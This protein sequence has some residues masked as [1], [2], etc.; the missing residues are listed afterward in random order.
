[1]SEEIQ[2]QGQDVS[3]DLTLSAEA[4]VKKFDEIFL[5]DAACPLP[6]GL[7]KPFIP[8]L[9]VTTDSEELLKAWKEAQ[10]TA[11]DAKDQSD[12][13]QNEASNNPTPDNL[14]QASQAYNAWV[15]AQKAADKAGEAYQDALK[16]EQKNQATVDDLKR[17]IKDTDNK[18]FTFSEGERAG[19]LKQISDLNQIANDWR[20]D[21]QNFVNMANTGVLGALDDIIVGAGFDQLSGL[22]SLRLDGW[23]ILGHLEDL[24]KFC[25]TF[26]TFVLGLKPEWAP[27]FNEWKKSFSDLG[28]RYRAGLDLMRSGIDLTNAADLEKLS[29]LFGNKNIAKDMKKL[30]DALKYVGA[31]D[32]EVNGLL[33]SGQEMVGAAGAMADA[34]CNMLDGAGSLINSV[35]AIQWA[36]PLSKSLGAWKNPFV[37]FNKMIRIPTPNASFQTLAKWQGMFNMDLDQWDEKIKAGGTC[38]W[39][40]SV[41]KS[42]YTSLHATPNPLGDPAK[43][44][45]IYAAMNPVEALLEGTAYA[46]GISLTPPA[47]DPPAK[48]A[49][50]TG[51]A[52]QDVNAKA[53]AGIT[54]AIAQVG[55]SYA[56]GVDAYAA[57]INAWIHG[58][59][60]AKRFEE[61]LNQPAKDRLESELQAAEDALAASE[62]ELQAAEDAMQAASDDAEGLKGAVTF[63]NNTGAISVGSSTNPAAGGYAASNV[64]TGARIDPETGMAVTPIAE[65]AVVN[66]I[67]TMKD[68]ASIS[69]SSAALAPRLEELGKLIYELGKDPANEDK[70]REAVAAFLSFAAAMGLQLNF[71]VDEDL[72][73]II[74]AACAFYAKQKK[75]R[76]DAEKELAGNRGGVPVDVEVKNL[77]IRCWL[78]AYQ[79]EAGTLAS[80]DFNDLNGLFT[81]TSKGTVAVDDTTGTLTGTLVGEFKTLGVLSHRLWI[82]VLNSKKEKVG[83]VHVLLEGSVERTGKA[84][85]K[86]SGEIARGATSVGEP[87][88]GSGTEPIVDLGNTQPAE[89][90]PVGAG[91]GSGSQCPIGDGTGNNPPAPEV[92]D[93]INEERIQ[94]GQ[95]PYPTQPSDIE[96]QVAEATTPNPGLPNSNLNQLQA[97]NP[98]GYLDLRKDAESPAQVVDRVLEQL[99]GV[100]LPQDWYASGAEESKAELESYFTNLDLPLDAERL[101]SL[102]FARTAD[103]AKDLSDLRWLS[104]TMESI[105]PSV[106]RGLV[107]KALRQGRHDGGLGSRSTWLAQGARLTRLR[108]L[109]DELFAFAAYHQADPRPHL[110]WLQ[111]HAEIDR[112]IPSPVDLTVDEGKLA[113][114][115]WEFTTTPKPYLGRI[116]LTIRDSAMRIGGPGGFEAICVMLV[117]AIAQ[118]A[119]ARVRRGE[120]P[121]DD[122]I[123]ARKLLKYVTNGKALDAVL[124][125]LVEE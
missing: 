70:I 1:M 108:P 25:D 34:A 18:V 21:V 93:K 38:G 2:N 100:F 109:L 16:I 39:L 63:P 52:V 65:E 122:L 79:W 27:Q 77:K 76:E 66:W 61:I 110:E 50:L 22:F 74:A 42:F 31:L 94:N 41:Q 56:A 5:E 62:S 84:T 83:D 69:N 73:N 29:T 47:V 48:D 44:N 24:N 119:A 15:E 40:G 67:D 64:N 116:F 58:K 107:F 59:D 87:E 121:T 68:L 11:D 54:S 117:S 23:Q 123:E 3:I 4:T 37:A 28:A 111:H 106:S 8:A 120:E 30:G 26:S 55:N 12:A 86:L 102:V 19:L 72:D 81:L 101:L 113:D 75:L 45:G 91:T 124:A 82:P 43:K 125:A 105:D 80:V 104:E 53:L 20:S 118:R 14:Q 95:T 32:A 33:L 78:Y 46:R 35:R 36:W 85:L 71:V 112:S 92:I 9:P 88:T 114:Q 13:A 98:T 17:Q 51:N 103:D 10:E 49:A 97:N 7:T 115:S 89:T 90:D 6:T 99:P 96:D 57:G 60:A